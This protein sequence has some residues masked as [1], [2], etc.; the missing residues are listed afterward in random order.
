MNVE[1]D[2]KP[3]ETVFKKSLQKAPPRLQSMLMHLQPCDVLQVTYKLGKELNIADT[4]SRAYL[5]EQSEQLRRVHQLTA[6]LPTTEEKLNTF[7]T[8]TAADTE[9][10]V[11]I[12][13][14][15]T[16]WPSEIRQVQTLVRKYWTFSEVL[17]C[18]D[19]LLFKNTRPVFLSSSRAEAH[20]GVF[21]C[22]ERSRDVMF[23]PNTEQD[24]EDHVLKCAVCNTFR[25]KKSKEP[26]TCHDIPERAWTKIEIDLFHFEQG[27]YL[28]CVDYYS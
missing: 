13:M 9:L 12:K 19:H 20:L 1:S 18:I 6:H 11:V 2:H 23:W 5:K 7:K 14:V 22:K 16:G 10:H 25:L 21:K 26:L 27:D 24:I 8:E 28:L 15:Q 3:K 17:A 4:L